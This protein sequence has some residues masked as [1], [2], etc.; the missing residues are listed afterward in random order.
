M[1]PQ[2]LNL[3]LLLAMS[4]CLGLA[5]MLGRNDA[6]PNVELMLEAQMSR[7]PAF[8]TF[9]PNPNFAD[10]MTLRTPPAGTIPRGELPLH[11]GTAPTEAVRAGQELHNPL[12]VTSPAVQ[13]RGAAV[14]ATY[15]QV[16]HGPTGLG[17]GPVTRRGVP[18]PLS[19]LTG[20]AVQMKDGEMFHVI[21]YGQGNMSAHAVQLSPSDRWAVVAYVRQLQKQLSVPPGVRLAETVKLFQGN[22]AACHG[23]DGSGTIMR[24]KL[25]NIPDFTSQA[26]QVSQTDVEIINRIDFGDMPNMPTFRYI[27]S[28][29]QILA[30]G[31]YIRMFA[32]TARTPTAA[33]P[34]GPV[35]ANLPPEKIFRDYC[36]ACHNVDGRGAIVRPAMPDIPDFTSAQW[37]ATSKPNADLVNAVLSGGKFMPPMKDKLSVA[38]AEKMV[39]FIRGFKDGKQVVALES[40]EVPKEPVAMPPGIISKPAT[41]PAAQVAAKPVTSSS[42]EPKTQPPVSPA[43]SAE[44]G[45]RVRAGAVIFRQY[46]IVCH[47]PDGTGSIMR[48]NLPP[49]PDFN[50]PN[51]QLE[52]SDPQLLVS[53][54]EGKGTLMPAN[55]GRITEDQARDLVAYV[56]AFGPA[57][58][59][60]STPTAQSDFEQRFNA[61]QQQ[62]ETL[63]KQLNAL[64]AAPPPK[65]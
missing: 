5:W 31:A 34:P 7:S 17:D 44:V 62:W 21:S 51:W 59:R 2:R 24:A 26:W 37:H 56:R 1:S 3:L 49:I 40:L 60:V 53:I 38:D 18:P 57:E 47:G 19:M 11:Y 25:P 52:H 41:A 28:R 39:K 20:K 42:S 4:G 16:C 65:R 50:N 6:Q 64:P 55:R 30:L 22:C 8:R 15:C 23:T 46:C 29:N 43:V 33:P 48:A 10:G 9:A 45:Q 27:L 32:S 13:E 58:L 12:A 63:E 54:L 14:F 36:M 61:L 35:A